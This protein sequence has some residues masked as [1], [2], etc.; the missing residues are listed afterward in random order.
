MARI[1]T[2]S[3]ALPPLHARYDLRQLLESM[4]YRI[5]LAR[6]RLEEHDQII[7]VGFP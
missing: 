6:R 2:D 5:S 1:E 7:P 3:Q 4:P